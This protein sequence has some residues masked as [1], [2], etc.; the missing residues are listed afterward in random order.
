MWNMNDMTQLEYQGQYVY[1]LVFDDGT[2]GDIDFSPYL[3]RGK[4]F[5]P[6]AAPLFFQQARIEG[7]TIAWPNG[8]DI[9]P[10]TLY[11]QCEQRSS[12]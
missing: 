11:E 8:I 6:L 3:K 1:H 12:R 5:Q 4:V 7:G 9:A 10:E 2:Q